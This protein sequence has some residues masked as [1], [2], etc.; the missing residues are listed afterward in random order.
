[1]IQAIGIV[2]CTVASVLWYVPGIRLQGSGK[3][4]KG[5]DF[6]RL[7]L[8]YGLLYCCVL[9]IITEL[10][11]DKIMGLTGLS[12]KGLPYDIFSD[13]FRAALLEELFKFTAFLLAYRKMKFEK[14]ISFIVACGMM[15]LVYG[16]V[17]KAALGNIFAMVIGI[18]S[19]MHLMWQYNQ[20]AHF[21]EYLEARKRQD[22]KKARKELFF[23]VAGIFL[24]HALWDAILDVSNYCINIETHWIW[25]TL[26]MILVLSLL[27]VGVIYSIKTVKKV[28]SEAKTSASHEET[29]VSAEE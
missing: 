6:V 14:K 19:P 21:Y 2:L 4:L 16:I 5:K 3:E 9:I 26:G 8:V 11:F 18:L 22:T 12:E 20:G 10:S 15:G 1:M 13:F 29:E 7:A 28:W 24:F 17:E 23:A 27:A 25:P